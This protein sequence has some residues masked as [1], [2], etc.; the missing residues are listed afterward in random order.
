MRGL[1]EQE[2]CFVRLA[3]IRYF[4]PH[5]GRHSTEAAGLEHEHAIAVLA[6][7]TDFD[8]ALYTDERS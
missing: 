5:A 2:A 1:H 3:W 7:I 4:V 8:I 6:F